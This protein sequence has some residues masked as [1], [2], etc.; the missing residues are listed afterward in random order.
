MDVTTNVPL[1]R[2]VCGESRTHGSHG[3]MGETCRGNAPRSS[4]LQRHAKALT[5]SRMG[6]RSRS[7]GKPWT[8]GRELTAKAPSLG[9]Y[10][11]QRSVAHKGPSER[12]SYSLVVVRGEVGA[13]GSNTD[14]RLCILQWQQTLREIH[15]EGPQVLRRMRSKLHVRCSTGGVRQ[16]AAR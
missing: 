4:P 16:R 10:G 2:A 5:K 8:P 1:S 13:M 15:G 7:V 14:E 11:V 9:Q 3:G 6:Q 12:A